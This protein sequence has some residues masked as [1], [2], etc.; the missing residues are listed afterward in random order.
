MESPWIPVF[1]G[2]TSKSKSN[3]KGKGNIT[4]DSSFRWND[5]EVGNRHRSARTIRSWVPAFAGMTVRCG[6]VERSARTIGAWV[7]AFAGMTM[8]GG[9]ARESGRTTANR[10]T[11]GLPGTSAP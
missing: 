5:G 3:G 4:M 8:K 2:M 10:L 9:M 6:N 7:P 11:S 1:A